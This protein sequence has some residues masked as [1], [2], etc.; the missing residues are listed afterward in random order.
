MP[1]GKSIEVFL[2][3][4]CLKQMGWKISSG[5]SAAGLQ[6]RTISQDIGMLFKLGKYE[7]KR[8]NPEWKTF[9]RN[10]QMGPKGNSESL[11]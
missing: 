10:L 8:L 4:V 1:L 5:S 7:S 2:L 6:L 9:N 3:F 11:K